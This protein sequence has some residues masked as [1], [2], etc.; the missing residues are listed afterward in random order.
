MK[1]SRPFFDENQLISLKTVWIAI[2][3]E[4]INKMAALTVF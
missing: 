2:G 3:F 4:Q 1:I